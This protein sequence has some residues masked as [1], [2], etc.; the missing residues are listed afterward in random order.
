VPAPRQVCAAVLVPGAAFDLEV[1]CIVEPRDHRGTARSHLDN[2]Q[3]RIAIERQARQPIVIQAKDVT[4]QAAQG[5]A[6]TDNGKHLTLVREK[7][8]LKAGHNPPC[9]IDQ[10]SALRRFE[11][12]VCNIGPRVRKPL[13]DFVAGVSFK[14]TNMQLPPRWI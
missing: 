9:Q 14:E 8:L 6:V 13:P 5:R 7:Q 1:G 2:G 11:E 3:P 10:C 12:A 4:E